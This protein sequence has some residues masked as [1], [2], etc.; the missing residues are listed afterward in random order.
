MTFSNI[1][2]L[3]KAEEEVNRLGQLKASK[4]KEL[5]LRKQ[6]QLQEIC[7][8]SHMEV[9]SPSEMEN[10]THLVESGGLTNQSIRKQ[11]LFSEKNS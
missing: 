11:F 4:M 7:S 6:F 9:P 10:L 2:Y 1:S 5:F 8:K 3:A